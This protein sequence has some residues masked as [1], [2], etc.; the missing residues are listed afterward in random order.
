LGR[1]SLVLLALILGLG[2]CVALAAPGWTLSNPHPEPPR[3]LTIQGKVLGKLGKGAKVHF[4]IVATDPRGWVD[5]ATVQIVLLLHDQGIQD[6]TYSVHDE[7]IA[8]SG[9][10]PVRFRGP[11]PV[12][13]GFLLVL[14]GRTSRLVR[15]TFS[16]RLD[17]WTRVLED[18]P[19]NAQFRLIAT[20][21]GGDVA[22]ARHRA[23][24]AGGFLSWGTFAVAA[25]VALF[26][27]G[28]FGTT[29]T[30]RRYRQREPSV[31]QILER[32][33]KDQKARP[34]AL[35]P[36]VDRGIG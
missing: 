31:W 17:L 18:I 27:G 32:R 10:E 20:S 25:A 28:F 19:R 24:V 33:L 34:P 29:L 13:G 12:E 36:S 14:N 21:D 2:W 30:S 23:E 1:R 3:R 7:T 26:L 35:A 11:E 15:Q 4:G 6:I 22:A 5:L 16:I 8:T 9:R